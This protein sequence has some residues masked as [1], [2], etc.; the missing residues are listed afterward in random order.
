[1]RIPHPALAVHDVEVLA[2]V[3]PHEDIT[4]NLVVAIRFD[5]DAPLAA[6]AWMGRLEVR[7]EGGKRAAAVLVVPVGGEVLG[8]RGIKRTNGGRSIGCVH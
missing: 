8:M 1:M 2:R 7:D 6:V 4:W 5:E 3:V